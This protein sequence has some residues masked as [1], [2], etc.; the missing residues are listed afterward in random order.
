[1]SISCDWPQVIFQHSSLLDGYL[2]G[3]PD[4]VI[5]P[6]GSRISL[7]QEGGVMVVEMVIIGFSQQSAVDDEKTIQLL[8]PHTRSP[9]QCES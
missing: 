3:H 8:F 2:S 9:M 1:M 4:E 5:V 6:E 7:S